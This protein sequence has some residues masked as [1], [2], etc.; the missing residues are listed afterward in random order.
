MH[1]VTALVIAIGPDAVILIILDVAGHLSQ[2]KHDTHLGVIFVKGESWIL[3]RASRS[4]TPLKSAQ[5]ILSTRPLGQGELAGFVE[6]V[7]GSDVAAI[8]PIVQPLA[9]FLAGY[10]VAVDVSDVDTIRRVDGLA[11]L[12]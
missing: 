2:L 7:S 1:L 11:G 4:Q 12:A 10:D 5:T 9:S 3:C 6:V 8:R